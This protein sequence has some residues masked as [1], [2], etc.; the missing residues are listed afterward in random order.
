MAAKASP[1]CPNRSRK[2]LSS[3]S[4]QRF[5]DKDEP[6][7]AFVASLQTPEGEQLVGLVHDLFHR[8]TTRLSD[9]CYLQ[10]LIAPPL[11][12]ASRQAHRRRAH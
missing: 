10:D 6:V 4:L 1:P 9:V 7:H 5:F 11:P 12:R 2:P 3:V 8:S